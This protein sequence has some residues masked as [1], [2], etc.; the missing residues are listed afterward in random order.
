MTT[1][2]LQFCSDESGAVTTD[3]VVLT[4]G[5]VGL[6]IATATLV[7]EGTDNTSLQLSGSLDSVNMVSFQD[8]EAPFAQYFYDIGVAAFPNS[9]DDAWRRAREAVHANAPAGFEYD[10]G[11]TTTRYVDMV[12]GYPIYVS[13]DGLSYSIGGQVIPAE[14]YDPANRQSFRNAFNTYY[15]QI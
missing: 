4:A 5:M 7:Y 13:N 8:G 11:F 15:G 6:A 3:W 1:R 12:T 2:V 14:E 10:P 9:R